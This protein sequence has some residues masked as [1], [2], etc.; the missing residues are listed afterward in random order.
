MNDGIYESG[1]YGRDLN[2]ILKLHGYFGVIF[3]LNLSS[4]QITNLFKT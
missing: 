3:I 2:D 1:N 4:R